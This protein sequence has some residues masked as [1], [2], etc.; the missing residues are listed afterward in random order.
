MSETNTQFDESMF[1][2]TNQRYK[3]F[4]D[5]LDKWIYHHYTGKEM[6]PSTYL[7]C[8][9]VMKSAG[10]KTVWGAGYGDKKQKCKPPVKICAVRGRHTRAQLLS[11][12]YDCPD[13]YGDPAL[14]LPEIYFPDIKQVHEIG[15][16]N[17]KRDPQRYPWAKN[18]NPERHSPKE[19]INRMLSCKFIVSTSLH[20]CIAADAYEIP[21]VWGWFDDN[22]LQDK[23]NN[24]YKYHDYYS[25]IGL[26]VEPC[27]MEAY[28]IK[29]RATVHV[30]PDLDLLKSARPF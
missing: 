13:I 20:G 2:K 23:D 6:P 7:I 3:N 19:Y 14:L 1:K 29:K 17:H 21:N 15:F 22:K 26:E 11:Q 10:N 28:E 30:K 4:G 12:G 27:P 25:A 8:G 18:I 9:S 5:N 24:Y 16:I